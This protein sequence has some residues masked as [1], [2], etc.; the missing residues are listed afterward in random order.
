[1]STKITSQLAPK[2][3][4]TLFDAVSSTLAQIAPAAAI[5]YG[6]PVIFLATGTGS[7]LTLLIAALAVAM[8]GLS[9]TNFSKKY[10]SSGSLVKY[11]GMTFGSVV[12]TASA[13]I[14]IVG[15]FF[16]AA[17]AFIELGGWTADSLALYG[18]HI[19]WIIPTILLTLFIWGL[20]IVGI[21]RSTKIASVALIIE[22]IVLLVVSILILFYPPEPLSLEP[23]HLSSIKGG[24]AGIGLGFPLAVYLFIG[25]E[26]SV[27]LAEETE[28]PE[29]NTSRA[30]LAS[31]AIMAIFYIFVTYCVIQGFSNSA[32]ALSK[33]SN[34]FMELANRYLNELAI[35]AIIAGF[36]SIVGMSIA[37]LNAFSRIAFNSSKEGLISTKFSKVSK[38]GTPIGTL[39]LIMG[40]GLVLAILFGI[41]SKN[42]VVGFG[43]VSTLGTIP[44]LLIYLMLN[45]AVIFNKKEKWPFHRKFIF[46]I[47][48]LVSISLPIWAMVQPGQPLPTGYFPWAILAICIV[49]LIY[50]WFKVR[51]G[52]SKASAINPLE[53][54]STQ[55]K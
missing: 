4:L 6:L 1:M 45:L 31:I 52:N 32:S 12:G 23:F 36:T 5:Y 2:K 53:P 39:T 21:D 17:S 33:S 34:P 35:F 16:L 38:W 27:A 18:I 13:I 55:R 14:F 42:W 29:R 48:G 28:N 20:T 49:S 15:T 41:F 3:R 22:V 26:N 46:P 44:I 43:Y 37:C 19:H 9:L 47:L 51:K 8:V 54:F 30:V 10:P 50:S 7:P 40:I 11:I 25:F 24:L